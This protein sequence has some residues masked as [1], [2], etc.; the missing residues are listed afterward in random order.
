MNH[1]KFFLSLSKANFLYFYFF[2]ILY[3]FFFVFFVF[4]D[5]GDYSK[6]CAKLVSLLLNFWD[7]AR[8]IA[9]YFCGIAQNMRTEL[10]WWESGE[11][12][13]NRVCL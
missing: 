5:L 3:F 10:L 7:A 4:I 12:L 6:C 13:E 8:L 1:K 9:G 11:V 2:S